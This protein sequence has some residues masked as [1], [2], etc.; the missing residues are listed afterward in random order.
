MIV[1]DDSNDKL[2]A[3]DVNTRRRNGS[4]K[5]IQTARIPLARDENPIVDETEY[6]NS[7]NTRLDED[8]IG[9]SKSYNE[10]LKPSTERS[11]N[12]LGKERLQPYVREMRRIK[13]RV[14][15]KVSS[16]SETPPNSCEQLTSRSLDYDESKQTIIAKARPPRE[17]PPWTVHDDQRSRL[18]THLQFY[19]HPGA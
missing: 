7:K 9:I 5:I 15:M 10:T 16:R 13:P 14:K 17:K 3:R 19:N 6:I 4:F 8:Y 2:R 18:S 11:M 12:D 1:T